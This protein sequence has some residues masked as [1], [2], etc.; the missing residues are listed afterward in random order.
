MFVARNTRTGVTM[1]HALTEARAYAFGQKAL[2]ADAKAARTETPDTTRRAW[3]I[4]ARDWYRMAEQEETKLAQKDIEQ[5][6]AR[7]R[8][9]SFS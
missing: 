1:Q 2:Q 7:L 8:H 9:I 3:L 6:I 5:L 4:V